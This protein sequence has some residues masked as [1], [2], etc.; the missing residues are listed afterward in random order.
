VTALNLFTLPPAG[1]GDD[2]P[3]VDGQPILPL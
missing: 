2:L 1:G 3:L